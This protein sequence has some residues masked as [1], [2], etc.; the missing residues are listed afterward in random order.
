MIV[1]SQFSKDVLNHPER[2]CA[3]LCEL[4]DSNPNY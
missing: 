3:R 1:R 2:R 4:R